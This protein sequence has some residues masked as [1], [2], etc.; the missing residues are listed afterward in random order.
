MKGDP[1]SLEYRTWAIHMVVVGRL[2][3]KS[4]DQIIQEIIEL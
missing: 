4:D 3:G 2:R 1:S